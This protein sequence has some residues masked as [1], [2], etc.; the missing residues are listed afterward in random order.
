M[1][2]PLDVEIRERLSQ[3]LAGRISLTEFEDW[4][5]PASWNV[6]LS[7]NQLAEELV[8][9]IEAVLA[10]ASTERWPEGPIK[11]ALGPLVEHYTAMLVEPSLVSTSSSN[12]VQEHGLGSSVTAEPAGFPPVVVHRISVMAS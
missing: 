11:E 8:Y 7:G 12:T 6:H 1:P 3:Y 5:I 9:D 4:F 10:Q 2:A